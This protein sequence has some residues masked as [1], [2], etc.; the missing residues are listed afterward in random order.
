M[1]SNADSDLQHFLD[2]GDTDSLLAFVKATGKDVGNYEEALVFFA[3]VFE[4]LSFGLQPRY[5]ALDLAAAKQRPAEVE[6]I[7]KWMDQSQKVDMQEAAKR[8]LSRLSQAN[9]GRP[10]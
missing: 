7:V 9:E 4:A 6:N 1:A 5:E 3:P 8:I 10:K 2:F